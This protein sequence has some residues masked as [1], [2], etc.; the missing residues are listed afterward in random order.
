MIRSGTE[1]SGATDGKI[2]FM[3][4]GRRKT[5]RVSVARPSLS[6]LIATRELDPNFP[7]MVPIPE[8]MV[9]AMGMFR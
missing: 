5:E 7:L 6:K 2:D 4:S 3:P 1:K 9:S 8:L